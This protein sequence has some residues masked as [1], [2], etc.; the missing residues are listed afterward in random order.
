MKIHPLFKWFG[1]KWQSAKHYP[2]PMHD[3]IVEPFAGGAGYALNYADRD[4]IIW[5]D[6]PNLQAL[7]RWIINDATP[8][9][10]SDI[11]VGLPVGHDIR[12]I[13]LSDG[14]ALLL[15]H[16]QRTNNVG[17]CWTI[18]PWG[19]KPG[20]WTANARARVADEIM[21]VKHWKF[22]VPNWRATTAT[23]FIDPPYFYNYRYRIGLPPFSF[24]ALA[25][26]VK[27]IPRDSL[28]IVCEATDKVS[29]AF[30]TYLPF[31]DSH[32]SVTSRRK[33]TQSHHS[34]ELSY[35]RR[36]TL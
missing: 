16:W 13:G 21:A 10:V 33:S 19:D 5:D 17:D 28:V 2:A 36:P 27:G 3:L 31:D 6:D 29:G 9:D 34:H 23:W 1:S 32:V 7:W 4:V 11:P 35:I 12:S 20:Q 30:P 22:E 26:C 15:K 24:D 14:Q 8:A 18:S 25:I